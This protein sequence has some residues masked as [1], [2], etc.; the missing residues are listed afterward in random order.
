MDNFFSPVKDIVQP[1][2]RGDQEGYKSEGVTE[3]IQTSKY[4]I[5]LFENLCNYVIMFYLKFSIIITNNV[6]NFS[7][8]YPL[9]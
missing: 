5:I 4:R 2:K 6:E 8:L 9:N 3:I 1:K 7:K